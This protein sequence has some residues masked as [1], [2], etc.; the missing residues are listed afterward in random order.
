MKKL[1]KTI[2]LV[3]IVSLSLILSG[4]AGEFTGSAG[5][6]SAIM[7]GL[8]GAGAGQLIGG[9]T[10]ATI[11]GAAIGA[12]AG[13]LLGAQQ[14]K[15]RKAQEQTDAR[16]EQLERNANEVRIDITNS[17]GSISTVVLVRDSYGNYFGPRGER[18]TSLPSEEQLSK[19]YGF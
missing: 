11:G 12:G 15:Q 4:C 17:N 19:I 5:G 8:L 13:Y 1:G 9:D 6:D 14:D 10:K 7:G 3:C 18:Y 16:L 2:C